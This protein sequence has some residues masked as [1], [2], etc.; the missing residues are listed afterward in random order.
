MILVGLPGSGKSTVGAAVARALG[1]RLIDLDA[2]IVRRERRSIAEIFARDG[3]PHF[4]ALEREA[5]ER[6]RALPPSVIAPGGGWATVPETVAILRPPART[7]YL[8]VSPRTA[9]RRIR[10]SAH[11]RPL[12]R[13]GRPIEILERLLA[14]RAA[15]Y[16][17][18]DLVVD[19][20][21][22][23]RQEVVNRIVALVSPPHGG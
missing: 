20:E 9:A 10:R 15:A 21:V 16:E 19:A 17:A 14:A 2:E 5:T 13:A 6:L 7:A 4:R 8:R 12:L 1:R 3:E 23:S 11:V 18:A 22:L